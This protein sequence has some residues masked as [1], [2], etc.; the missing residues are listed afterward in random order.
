MVSIYSKNNFLPFDSF[1]TVREV[2]KPSKEDALQMQMLE[3]PKPSKEDALQMQMLECAKKNMI[4]DKATDKCACPSG[5]DLKISE[6]RSCPLCQDIKYVESCEKKPSQI[7]NTID[8][9]KPKVEKFV[10]DNKQL[11][12]GA[13]ILLGMI[14]IYKILK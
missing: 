7:Q 2:P 6:T 9:V 14:I 13:G 4:F 1:G 12:T 10:Y 8:D 3:V 5:Y 11:V